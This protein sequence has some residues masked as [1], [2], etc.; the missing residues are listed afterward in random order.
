M[1]MKSGFL[2]KGQWHTVDGLK[3]YSFRGRVGK[4]PPVLYLEWKTFDLFVTGEE[5]QSLHRT[6]QIILKDAA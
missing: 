1:T 5:A 4:E 2:Y 6:I 3:G